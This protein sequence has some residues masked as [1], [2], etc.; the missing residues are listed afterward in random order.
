MSSAMMSAPSRASRTACD[1]PCARA[2]PVTNA[3]LPCSA[4]ACPDTYAPFAACQASSELKRVLM[5]PVGSD[6]GDDL[7]PSAVVLLVGQRAAG[8]QRLQL[9]EPLRD[10][11]LRGCDD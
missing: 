4:P 7:G 9:L 8:T 6:F 3:T 5:R 1:R 2:A 11:R 10:R